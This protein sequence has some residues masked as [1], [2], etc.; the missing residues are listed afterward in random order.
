M[1]HIPPLRS[2]HASMQLTKEEG[3]KVKFYAAIAAA[4]TVVV[5]ALFRSLFTF[6]LM[7][8]TCYAVYEIATV[9]NNVTELFGVEDI[10]DRAIQ[11]R[12]NALS[13]LGKK[14][15]L[16]RFIFSVFTPHDLHEGLAE[17]R[18]NM[19]L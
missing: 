6:G 11:S 15:P 16:A 18:K 8:A 2:V 7:G 19:T 3:E 12:E 13:Q 1:S 4:V 5:F 17:S 9:V 14:A 10:G